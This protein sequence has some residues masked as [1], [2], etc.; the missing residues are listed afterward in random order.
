MWGGTDYSFGASAEVDDT[1][2]PAGVV[3]YHL[4]AA[5][6]ACHAAVSTSTRLP[7]PHLLIL[8]RVLRGGNN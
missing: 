2:G 4:R 8:R 5:A 3:F 1:V 7:P 6:I